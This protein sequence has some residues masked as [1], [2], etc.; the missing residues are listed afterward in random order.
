MLCG[1][2]DGLLK[3][4]AL[5]L[6]F[7]SDLHFQVNIFAKI[8]SNTKLIPAFMRLVFANVVRKYYRHE[9][10]VLGAFRFEAKILKTK[11]L[12]SSVVVI[13]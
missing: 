13:S 11:N 3:Y 2:R 7:I 6:D 12:F 5:F 9:N 10:V 8:L 1:C 4:P